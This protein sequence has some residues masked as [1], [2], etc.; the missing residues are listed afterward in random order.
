MFSSTMETDD[1]SRTGL[2]QLERHEVVIRR[3]QAIVEDNLGCP[4]QMT[5]ISRQ[6][7]VSAR[8]LRLASG[9]RLGVSPK[10]YYLR[11][12]MAS[13]HQVLQAGNCTV[14]EVAT[15][16]GFWELGRFSGTYRKIHGESPSVTRK[17]HSSVEKPPAAAPNT[18][19]G[20]AKTI[21]GFG[22][23][24]DLT[25]PPSAWGVWPS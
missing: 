16:F 14:T 3:F 5:E 7:G 23:L 24:C 20:A 12:R 1:L 19:M 6:I 25:D 10:Q 9:E 18:L 4:L 2:T 13:A 21:C 8:T 17:F 15:E 11:R 22:I